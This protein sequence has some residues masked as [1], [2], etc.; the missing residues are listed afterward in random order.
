MSTK[1]DEAA[2]QLCTYWKSSSSNEGECRRHAPQTFV[3]KVDNEVKFES[4]FSV[5]KGNDWCGDF[6]NKSVAFRVN[7][8]FGDMMSKSR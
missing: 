3:F 8:I 2:C 5:T 7:K 4:H 6:A 1:T